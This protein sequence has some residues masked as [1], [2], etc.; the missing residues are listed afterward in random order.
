[1]FPC[2]E[3]T[4]D[5]NMSEWMEWWV[6][7]LA[8]A[9]WQ[10]AILAAMIGS[11]DLLA[12][13]ASSRFRY[14]LWCIVLAR[15]CVP[16]GLAVPLGWLD[17]LT[18]FFSAVFPFFGGR[19]SEVLTGIIGTLG[20]PSL[21]SSTAGYVIRT[22]AALV[23]PAQSGWMEVLAGIWIAGIAAISAALV[24]SVCRTVRLLRKCQTV[25]R[26]DLV[27]LLERLRASSGVACPVRLK[28][29]D[30]QDSSGPAVAGVFR[31]MIFLP[32]MMADTWSLRDIKP[33]LLHELAHIRRFDI[34]A[35]WVQV[36]VQAIFFFHPVVWFVN[37]RLRI[38]REEV[39]DD[40]AVG[41]LGSGKTHYA[42]SIL[43]FLDEPHGNLSPWFAA[44]GLGE[45]RSR[46]GRRVKRIMKNTYTGA[47]PLNAASVVFIFI[48]GAAGVVLSS[49]Q[50]PKA[51]V[52]RGD[53]SAGTTSYLP[54]ITLR[55]GTPF[56]SEVKE[57][58]QTALIDPAKKRSI[59]KL[60]TISVAWGNELRPPEYAKRAAI[61]LEKAVNSF[62]TL[63]AKVETN[64][65]LDSD[66]L[67]E[68][69]FL[70]VAADM[71]F[72]LTK[73]ERA[74]FGEYLR[75]GGFAF[76]DNGSPEKEYGEA[77]NSLRRML[78]DAFDGAAQF[79]PIP[80]DYP[81]YHVFFDFE[82][83]PPQGKA[84]MTRDNR[85]LEGVWI[86]GRLAVV[87]CDWGYGY[88]WA[89][90]GPETNGPQ[91]KMGVNLILYALLQEGGILKSGTGTKQGMQ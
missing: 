53:A 70:Y 26:E 32:R 42:R 10:A 46:I 59:G 74:R 17:R 8:A 40:I 39:C 79:R 85:Y 60:I 72:T 64:I 14:W 57:K 65:S 77:E 54:D 7:C 16:V 47:Y 1:M 24:L 48:V 67:F 37:R 6:R 30:I 9:S 36:I 23:N 50:P 35:N 69:P 45:G 90:M 56:T 73:T 3:A 4:E 25:E 20:K 12:S 58:L 87:Y 15:L 5:W 28:Y 76:V 88:K 82:D 68:T 80:I 62:T 2:V 61:N 71:P 81:I 29:L 18:D 75:K 84:G 27:S 66:R 52:E 89:E 41:M 11:I 91:R 22:P 44:V 86:A 83:G 63:N 31:P 21:V 13:R 55:E 34:I 33:V 38:V 49:A 51:A 78:S 19:T 43:R